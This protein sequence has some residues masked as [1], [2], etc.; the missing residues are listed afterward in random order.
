MDLIRGWGRM[1]GVSPLSALQHLG[2]SDRSVRTDQVSL[3]S[4]RVFFRSHR[5][6]WENSLIR[7]ADTRPEKYYYP[8][9]KF[10]KT[11]DDWGSI[12]PVTDFRF[13]CTW[14]YGLRCSTGFPLPPTFTLALAFRS[15]TTNR[16]P[17]TSPTCAS[18]GETRFLKKWRRGS[19][20]VRLDCSRKMFSRSLPPLH[21]HPQFYGQL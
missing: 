1:F 15:V 11:R 13:P 16:F 17:E 6:E 21:V 8:V 5:I 12:T 2:I 9:P 20:E 19:L 10:S 4:N 3:T 18:N 14:T 7:I